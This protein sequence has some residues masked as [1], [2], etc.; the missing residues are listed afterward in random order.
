M[1]RTFI[2]G[3]YVTGLM[4]AVNVATDAGVVIEIGGLPI[5]LA[6]D[7]APFIEML[8]ERYAGFMS[9]GTS[10]QIHFD[11]ELAAAESMLGHGDLR[12]EQGIR[13]MDDGARGFS[14][15]VES[16]RGARDHPADHQSV[17]ARFRCCASCTRFC[18]R[19]KAVSWCMP[20]APFA[21]A[22]RFC[23]PEFPAQGRPRWR[24][25]RRPTRAAY[26]RDFLR[27]AARR[28]LLSP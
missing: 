8:R 18:S 9:L 17:L 19:S 22:A 16:K 25:W 28:R 6:T 5:R 27:D 21:T 7:D 23:L 3:K 14:G 26:R 20:R 4:S 12:V 15:G 1:E 24:G 10:A 13:A 2:Q 11:I